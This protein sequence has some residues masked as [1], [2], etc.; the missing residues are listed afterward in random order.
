MTSDATQHLSD[1]SVRRRQLE[2][3]KLQ[4]LERQRAAQKR[5]ELEEEERCAGL[6]LG[7]GL[8]NGWGYERAGPQGVG[9]QWAGLQ[10]TTAFP[11]G[12][13]DVTA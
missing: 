3:Q 1:A 13:G 8:N 4:E 10:P 11:Q 6:Q 2:R 12:I 9:H 5:R 7:V